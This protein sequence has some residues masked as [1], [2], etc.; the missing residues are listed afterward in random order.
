MVPFKLIAIFSILAITLAGGYYPLRHP[1]TARQGKGFPQGEA[2]AAGVFLALSLLMM[3]PSAFHLFNKTMPS[4]EFPLAAILAILSFS[5]LLA[6]E[7]WAEKMQKKGGEENAV[8]SPV[9]V[10]VIMT[11]MIAI[12]SFLLGTALGVSEGDAAVFIFL[13]ILAHKGTAAFALALQMVKSRL[14]KLGI[15]LWFS[16]FALSTPSGIFFGEEIHL[17][18]NSHA[19]L[20]AKAF[21]L[22]LASGVFLFLSCLHGLGHT[23]MI[24]HIGKPRGFLLMLA[25]FI[26]TA[27]TR[28]MM[29]EVH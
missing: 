4:N 26:I 6:I 8:L 13:A 15:R 18:L 22:S 16:L 10:P 17:W 12:P 23:A 25:G 14:N 20:L 1:Q 29:A 9:S 5:S 27:L 2:F 24:K 7:Q 21:I 11:I 3:L 19:L 28:W